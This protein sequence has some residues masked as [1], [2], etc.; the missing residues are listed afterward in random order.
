M[1]QSFECSFNL[2]GSS[3]QQWISSAG[4]KYF[5]FSHCFYKILLARPKHQCSLNLTSTTGTLGKISS[6]LPSVLHKCTDAFWTCYL[7]LEKSYVLRFDFWVCMWLQ[8]N[9]FICRVMTKTIHWSEHKWYQ[10]LLIIGW[11]F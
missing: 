7:P 8:Q 10:G 1:F 5:M 4:P 11:P 2:S 9:V 3:W 6:S